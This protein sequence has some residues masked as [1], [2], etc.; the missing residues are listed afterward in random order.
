MAP[1]TSLYIQ[2]IVE[3][4]AELKKEVLELKEMTERHMSV[5]SSHVCNPP[6]PAYFSN[7]FI[8]EI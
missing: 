4:L 7:W 1:N 6:L 3:S 2:Q 8:P 5:S